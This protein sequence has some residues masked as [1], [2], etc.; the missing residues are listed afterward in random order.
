VGRK[1]EQMINSS[2][3]NLFPVKIES[4][5]MQGSPLLGYVAAIGDR[6]RYVTALIVLDPEKLREFA[7]EHELDGTHA[8]LVATPEV[9]AEVERAVAAGNARLAR[10]EQVRAWKVLDAEWKPGSAEMTNTLKLRRAAI[11]EKYA[12]E[13]EALYA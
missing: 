1:K 3:K 13:I 10:V 5:I 12:A 7:V 2:G 6:R 9:Q 11:D 4:V 8:E